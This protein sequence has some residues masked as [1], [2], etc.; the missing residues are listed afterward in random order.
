MAFAI[1]INPTLLIAYIGRKVLPIMTTNTSTK[2]SKTTV[3]NLRSLGQAIASNTPKFDTTNVVG[4]LLDMFASDFAIMDKATAMRD[5][6][7]Q[8]GTMLTDMVAQHEGM[9]KRINVSAARQFTIGKLLARAEEAARI[10]IEGNSDAK[11]LRVWLFDQGRGNEWKQSVIEAIHGELE[12]KYGPEIKELA[13]I[14]A[15]ALPL[16][17]EATRLGNHIDQTRD[18]IQKLNAEADVLIKGKK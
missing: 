7:L 8:L 11:K 1:T 2:N 9:L 10:S 15:N 13:D 12:K 3:N 5:E 16:I 4:D 18:T 6:A 14:K 17:Q